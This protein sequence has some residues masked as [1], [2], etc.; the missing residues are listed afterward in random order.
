MLH[1]R[2][3]PASK[4]PCKQ[5]W[6]A[7]NRYQANIFLLWIVLRIPISMKQVLRFYLWPLFLSQSHLRM[8]DSYTLMPA[9]FFFCL[10]N[11]T[12]ALCFY[13]HHSRLII[14]AMTWEDFSF[15]CFML[16]CC[17]ICIFY[18]RGMHLAQF[19]QTSL[20]ICFDGMWQL[21]PVKRYIDYSFKRVID[22][23][24]CYWD[25]NVFAVHSQFWISTP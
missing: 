1:K 23:H 14:L 17:I 16:V 6:N 10:L 22:F 9:C 21:H 7:D 25:P 3:V 20:H 12:V 5:R 8:I 11:C 19:Q 24:L 13:K 18:K 15:S 2:L 4:G